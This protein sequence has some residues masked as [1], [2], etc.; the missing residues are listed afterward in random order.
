MKFSKQLDL[1]HEGFINGI[2]TTLQ[3]QFDEI[4]VQVTKEQ[5]D[6]AVRTILRSRDWS[7]QAIDFWLSK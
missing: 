7:D 3:Y 1:I 2:R 6:N 5:F 4:G